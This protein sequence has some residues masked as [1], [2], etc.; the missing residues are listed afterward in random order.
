M[1]SLFKYNSTGYIKIKGDKSPFDGDTA[2]WVNRMNR[3]YDGHRR[4]LIKSQDTKCPMCTLRLKVT[5]E[6]H[7]HHVNGNH[8]D[9][10]WQNLQV[11]HS[12]CHQTHHRL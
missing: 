5:D 2:Y 3:I 9:N 11:L 1:T 7:V 12:D 4:S 10:R 6:I 8:S